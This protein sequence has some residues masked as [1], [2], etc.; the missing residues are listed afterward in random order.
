[1][2]DS[3][4]RDTDT[5]RPAANRLANETSPYLLQ[6]AH[7]PVDWFPWG[8][9]AF[10]AARERDVPIFLSIGYSTC[11]WCHVMERQVFENEALAAKMNERFVSVKVDREERPD[12]D[13]LYMTATQLMTGRGGWPMSVFLT[14]PGAGADGGGLKPFWCGTYIPPEPSHGMP[15]FGGVLEGIRNA[16]DTQRDQVLDQANRVADAVTQTLAAQREAAAGGEGE[17]AAG[18]G[19]DTVQS[20]VNALLQTYDQE[21]GGFGGAPKFPQPANL[22]LLMSVYRVTGNEP[23]WP[24]IHQTLDRMA[25]GGMYDQIGGGFHRYSVDRQW[26]VPHFEKMLYDNGQLAEAYATAY[27]LKPAT[28]QDRSPAL[29][30]RVACETC[31]Y[32]LREMTDDTGAFW[33]AQDAEVDGREGGNYV[34]TPEQ[35]REA[36]T[37]E[38]GDETLAEFVIQLYG[39]DL[40]PNFEDPHPPEGETPPKV[41]VLFLPQPL[42]AVTE[43]TGLAMQEVG[44]KRAA[45]NRRLLAVRDRREQPGTDD[46]VI[47]SWNGM[48]IAGLAKAGRVFERGDFVDAAARAADAVLEHMVEGDLGESSG[49]LLR[50]MRRGVAKQPA[51]LEDYAHLAHGLVELQ[52][53]WSARHADD[54]RYLQQAVRLVAAAA[55]R[56][57]DE[58][59]GYYDTLADQA[60]LF[61]RP[62]NTYDGS[63]PSGHSVML[64]DTLDLAELTGDERWLRVA[65]MDLKSL[66]E[67]MRQRGGAMVHAVHALLR[68]LTIAPSLVGDA[69]GATGAEDSSDEDDPVT[70]TAMPGEVSLEGEDGAARVDV[71]LKIDEGFHVNAAQTSSQW[72]VPTRLSLQGAEGVELEVSYPE[73]AKGEFAFADEAL[74]VYEERATLSAT[75]RRTADDRDAVKPGR[76]VLE[77]Q[78]CDDSRCLTPRSVTV[79]VTLSP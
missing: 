46:K 49:T 78:A 56:F 33:S 17:L 38:D 5:P 13:D 73:P 55:H 15:G 2:T 61:V 41:N 48:M 58:R 36:I 44:E 43:S 66:A 42:S 45:V 11:Y 34:W 50:T 72:L 16:W 76:L 21:H 24:V 4:P 69:A 59:G 39:L 35:V 54:D 32:V 53:A 60:D 26:L 23:L 79:P 74:S 12:V 22:A 77:Y 51:Y 10:A 68:M 31:D 29:Y 28:E 18:L 14:P 70:V 1:M 64:H 8:E 25:R 65:A 37:A 57:G 71:T 62:R 47:A 19:P 63:V 6:H 67:P 52:R 75:L 40:G 9:E 3:S 30:R 20:V 7:N 27:E